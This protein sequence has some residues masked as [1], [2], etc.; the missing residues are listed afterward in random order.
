MDKHLLVTVSGE[1]SAMHG[2]RFILHFF[3]NVENLKLTLFYTAP[4]PP[5]VWEHEKNFESLDEFQR[6]S[7]KAEAKGRRA[8]EEARRFV[9]SLQFGEEQVDAKFMFRQ[10]STAMDILQEGEKG[11]YDA[12][13]LGR[14][15]LTR[16]ELLAEDSVS[17]EIIGHESIAPM[18]ICRWP[19]KHR[20]HVLLCLDGS[21]ASYRMA[22][23][24]GFM[25][26]DEPEHYIRLMRVVPS[27]TRTHRETDDIFSR[28][29]EILAANGVPESR[30][31]IAVR[32]GTPPWRA[33][34]EEAEDGMYAVV[35]LGRTGSGG[36]LFKRLFMGSTSVNL[37]RELVGAV[38]WVRP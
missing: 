21:D 22:D 26:A 18:W 24:V 6:L 8:L 16:L 35:A 17:K 15:G 14:R 37:M 19:E 29:T 27:G 25:L 33:I 2:I 28:A 9:C 30:I 20:Q 13:V 34:M 10:L 31:R 11:L 4:R 3:R 7:R 12:V 38:L 36:G 23:H 1:E 32:E 5:A